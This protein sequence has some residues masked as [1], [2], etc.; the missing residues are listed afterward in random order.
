MSDFAQYP[1]ETLQAVGSRLA[2][3]S[4]QISSKSRNAFE[5]DGM[6]PDQD[7]IGSA[8]SS[9]RTEW[10]ASLKKLGENIGGFGE[11]ST[12]I[13]AM[14]G[15]FDAELARA[16]DPGRSSPLPTSAAGQQ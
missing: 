13:G 3:I 7:R 9:F 14:S 12:Q 8:L 16:M 10:E 5:V 4:D 6:T 2:M 15:E 11:T 1:Y